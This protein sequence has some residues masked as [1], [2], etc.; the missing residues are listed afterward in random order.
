[1]RPSFRRAASGVA[2]TLALGLMCT[3][4]ASAASGAPGVGPVH[5]FPQFPIPAS[6]SC[7]VIVDH[8]GNLWSDQFTGNA[9]GEVDPA[10]GATHEVPLP[11]PGGAPGGQNLGPDGDIYF[12]E[13]GGNAIGKLDTVTRTITTIPFPWANA[14]VGGLPATG[15][16]ALNN[17]LG[18]P[19]DDTFGPDGKL[20]FALVGLNAI[21]SYDLTTHAFAKY[22]IPTPLSGPIAMERG[23]G[24]TIAITEATSDKIALFDTTTDTYTE[25]PIPTPASLP[26]GLTVSPDGKYLYFGET[27]GQ[28]VGRLDP[29]TGQIKEYPLPIDLSLGDPLPSPGQMRFGSDGNLYIMEGTFDVGDQVGQLNVITGA[30]HYVTTPTPLSSPCDLNNALPGKIIFGE[31]TGNRVAYFNIPNT[32]DISNS[33]PPY[34]ENL[35]DRFPAGS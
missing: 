15:S 22:P 13:V 35:P 26:G 9:M 29:A 4:G 24:N 20:Y 32:T 7:E 34:N 10:T 16:L 6:F 3:A 21:G 23:P 27:L 14:E 30:Y 17:G 11:N 1:M 33:I 5:E 31:F 19:F 12:V 25:Y 8:Q 28:K 2:A 18:V